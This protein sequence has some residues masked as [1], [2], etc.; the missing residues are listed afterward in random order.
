[1]K[2][3]MIMMGHHVG[4]VNPE[5]KNQMIRT[6]PVDEK[7]RGNLIRWARNQGVTEWTP[8]TLASFPWLKKIA[9]R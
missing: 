5:E 6:M 4:L 7:F 9:L 8:G 2:I 1:M 3:H